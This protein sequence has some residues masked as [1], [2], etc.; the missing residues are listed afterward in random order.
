MTK[1][2]IDARDLVVGCVVENDPRALGHALRLVRSIRWFGGELA[3]AQLMVCVIDAV[4]DSARRGFE[5]YGAD[6]RIVHSLHSRA[7]KILFFSEALTSGRELL[8]LL[9]DRTVVVQDPLPWMRRDA[10]QATIAPVQTVM[11]EEFERAFLAAR[12]RGAR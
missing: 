7:S 8:M 11:P 5:D 3:R 10:F 1:T 4:D 6:V 9:D 12:S 2:R